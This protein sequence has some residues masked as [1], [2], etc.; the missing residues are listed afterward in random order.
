MAEIRFYRN[1]EKGFAWIDL[2][3]F[4][5]FIAKSEGYDNTMLIN[6]LI[7]NALSHA[8]DDRYEETWPFPEYLE[9][10][11]EFEP[12]VKDTWKNRLK[13]AWEHIEVAFYIL[14]DGT[15]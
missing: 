4:K 3:K 7:Y 13:Q 2:D 10:K 11:Y 5:A 8:N 12:P 15:L 14:R 9:L 6:K 1:G